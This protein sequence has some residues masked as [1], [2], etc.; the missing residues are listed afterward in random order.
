M[1]DVLPTL[2]PGVIVHFHDIFLPYDY[3][4]MFRDWYWNEQY[5]LAAYL[6]GARDRIEVLM[7]SN[8]LSL[9]EGFRDKFAPF[10]VDLGARNDSWC[11]GGSFWFTHSAQAAA[12]QA[13]QSA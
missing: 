7:P 13:R 11:H 9:T 4:E 10:P 1:L 12:T 8:Y 5:L 2:R 3:P 6:L